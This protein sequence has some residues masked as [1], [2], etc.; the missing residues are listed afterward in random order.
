MEE[1]WKDINGFEGKYIVSNTGRVKSI[2]RF[3]QNH[4]KLQLLPDRILKPSAGSHGYYVVSLSGKTELLHRLIAA[5][6]IP[7]PENKKTVNHKN[8][9]KTDNSL[10]NLE[11]MTYSENVKHAVDLGI[12]VTVRGEHHSKTTLTKD[13]VLNIRQIYSS[14]KTSQYKLA[15]MYNVSRSCIKSITSNRTWVNI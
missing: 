10:D 14:G 15:D 4:T 13:Q 8:T 9:V 1:I 5:A 6:F 11:W 3:I 7:N 2:S 12:N